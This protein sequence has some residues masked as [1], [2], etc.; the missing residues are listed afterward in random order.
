LGDVSSH[1]FK[2]EVPTTEG[3]YQ[4]IWCGQTNCELSYLCHAFIGGC[5]KTI[6]G[7]HGACGPQLEDPYSNPSLKRSKRQEVR[8]IIDS[9]DLKL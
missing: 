7:A 4:L 3:C 8:S 5:T 1:I 2:A 9:I 6:G